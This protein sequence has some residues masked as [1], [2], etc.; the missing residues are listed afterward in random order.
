MQDADENKTEKK[1]ER[2]PLSSNPPGLAGTVF[3]LFDPSPSKFNLGHFQI[4]LLKR[5]KPEASH[6][7]SSLP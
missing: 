2:I 1:A 3:R 6:K 4:T 7:N 5:P